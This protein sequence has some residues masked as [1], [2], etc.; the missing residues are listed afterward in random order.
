[1]SGFQFCVP[2]AETADR[3]SVSLTLLLTAAAY[4][5]HIFNMTPQISYSTLIDQYVLL[6]EAFIAIM[7][8]EAAVIGRLSADRRLEPATLT[9][10]D[11]GCLYVAISLFVLIHVWF[12]RRCFKPKVWVARVLRATLRTIK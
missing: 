6:C 5:I 2:A 10:L 9:K 7:A 3:L 4:K 12:L 11:E 1:M 8:T